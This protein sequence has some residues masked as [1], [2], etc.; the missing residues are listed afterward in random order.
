MQFVATI[1]FCIC[2]ADIKAFGGTQ[3]IP[4]IFSECKTFDISVQDDFSE[5]SVDVAFSDSGAF[6]QNTNAG[7]VFVNLTMDLL[8]FA[9]RSEF[10]VALSE[11]ISRKWR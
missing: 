10:L 7:R 8:V 1:A 5:S 2:R 11:L 4:N 3:N 9:N 6:S